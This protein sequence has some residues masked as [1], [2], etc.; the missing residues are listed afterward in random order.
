M[1][2]EIDKLDKEIEEI[3][4]IR[5]E[6]AALLA[7][8]QVIEGLQS[9]RSE[10]VQLLDQ[11]VRQLPEGVYLK[12]DEADRRQGQ[13]GRLRPVERARLHPDAQPRGLAVAGEPGAGGDQGRAFARQ[14]GQPH[15]RIQHEHL[16]Q[17]RAGRGREGRTARAAPRRRV[18]NELHR[19]YSNSRYEAARQLAVARQGRRA[20]HPFRGASG[21]RVFPVLAGADR[22]QSRRAAQDVAKQKEASSRRRSSPS[23]STLYKQQRARSS[24]PFGALLKQLPNKSEMDALLIDINQAGPRARPAVRA[25]Q[26]RGE[27]ELHRVLRRAAGQHQGDRQLPRHG[28]VRERR[29][30]SCRAS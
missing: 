29:R 6:T 4:K 5:D 20:R 12:A 13:S 25:V 30:P 18:R 14:V 17:A 26:A 19:R 22:T 24:R 8:K 16:D 3:R 15:Q 1:K 10:T 2:A 9:N 7:K 11:L 28:R 27:G 23:T 21:R